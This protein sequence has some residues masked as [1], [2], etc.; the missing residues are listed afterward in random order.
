[1]SWYVKNGF[2]ACYE[3]APFCK[4]KGRGDSTYRTGVLV[5]RT[6]ISKPTPR[7]VSIYTYPLVV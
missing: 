5:Y 2:E 1:M 6:T 3:T 4:Q 7:V